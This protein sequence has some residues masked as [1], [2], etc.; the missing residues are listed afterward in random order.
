M[1]SYNIMLYLRA[2]VRRG[3]RRVITGALDQFD[4]PGKILKD[5]ENL[6]YKYE[7]LK[8]GELMTEFERQ[9]SDFVFF[10]C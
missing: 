1:L 3:F 2:W 6:G 10:S 4:G 5:R 8:K 9:V 7:D